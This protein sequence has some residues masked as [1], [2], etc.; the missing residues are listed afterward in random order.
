MD[1]VIHCLIDALVFLIILTTVL[2]LAT[3]SVLKTNNYVSHVARAQ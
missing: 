1:C 3:V 2:F